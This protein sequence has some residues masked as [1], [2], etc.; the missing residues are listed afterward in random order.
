[1]GKI[2]FLFITM[3]PLLSTADSIIVMSNYVKCTDIKEVDLTSIKQDKFNWLSRFDY[4][5]TDDTGFLYILGSENSKDPELV[6][7]RGLPSLGKQNLIITRSGEISDRYKLKYKTIIQAIFLPKKIKCEESDTNQNLM[8][9]R[10]SEQEKRNELVKKEPKKYNELFQLRK[11]EI[12]LFEESGYSY[13]FYPPNHM[14]KFKNIKGS[15]KQFEQSIYLY[16]IVLDDDLNLRYPN[17][18]RLIEKF[19]LFKEKQIMP[20]LEIELNNL[21]NNYCER[22]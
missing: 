21:Y 1:M 2:I 15:K 10:Y 17:Q 5:K 11:E 3:L 16:S 4:K 12:L 8:L 19:K 13:Y 6:M 22:C 20:A 7:R 9:Q 18:N 14:S